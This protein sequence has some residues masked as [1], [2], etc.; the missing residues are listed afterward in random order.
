MSQA[1]DHKS[2]HQIPIQMEHT[3]IE[4]KKDLLTAE[5]KIVSLQAPHAHKY[6][7][8]IYAN[9]LNSL[10]CGNDLFKLVDQDIYYNAYKKYL[11]FLFTLSTTLIKVAVLSEDEDIFFG[12]SVTDGDTLHYVFVPEIYRKEGFA[13]ALVPSTIKVITHLTNTGISLWQSKIPKAIY[14]PF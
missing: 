10:R 7:S 9:W 8:F 12:F 14:N 13:K 4:T 3:N 6:K 1:D 5:Y 11:D 2:H